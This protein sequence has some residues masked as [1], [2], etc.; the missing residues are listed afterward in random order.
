M[1]QLYLVR[2]G[3]TIENAE[4]VLQG[5]MPGNLSEQGKEQVRVLGEELTGQHFDVMFVSDLHRTVQTAEL[6]NEVLQ[7]P[8][9]KTPILRE[10]DWGE[11]TGKKITDIDTY[12]FPPSVETVEHIF[13][14]ATTFINM[15]LHNYDGKRILAVSHG[16]FSRA[17][18]ACNIGKTIREVPRMKNAEVR[19]L[20]LI[21]PIVLQHQEAEET[22]ATAN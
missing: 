7:L 17:L 10:R 2:H 16:L 6:L 22:G 13:E 18:Q 3:E 9:I 4:G 14:R 11:V 20:E 8:I 12:D 1:V 21:H 19:L 15:L 5:L